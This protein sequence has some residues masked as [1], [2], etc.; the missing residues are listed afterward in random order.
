MNGQVVSHRCLP[1]KREF[2]SG[3]DM[4]NSVFLSVFPEVFSPR[5]QKPR[6]VY[7]EYVLD[8]TVSAE[9]GRDLISKKN[10]LFGPGFS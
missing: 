1:F 3:H 4:E 8:D 9:T 10:A 6:T 2:D 7:P 5:Y